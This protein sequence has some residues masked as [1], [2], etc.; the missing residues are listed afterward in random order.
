[1][2]TIAHISDLH[3][4]HIDTLIPPALREALLQA[5][6]DVV[7]VSGDSTQRVRRLRVRSRSQLSRQPAVSADRRPRQPRCAVARR[8]AQMAGAAGEAPVN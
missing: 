3:F 5:R 4:G 7:V 6:P 1:M 8:H 2:R